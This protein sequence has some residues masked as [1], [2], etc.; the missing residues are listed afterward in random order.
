MSLYPSA[1][2]LSLKQKGALYMATNEWRGLWRTAIDAVM[3][4]F[5]QVPQPDEYGCI[6]VTDNFDTVVVKNN[7]DVLIVFYTETVIPLSTVD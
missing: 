6:N 7:I 1:K 2:R 3:A 5:R 4:V